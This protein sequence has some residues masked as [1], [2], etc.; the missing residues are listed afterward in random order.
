MKN[1]LELNT[2]KTKRAMWKPVVKGKFVDNVE[3]LLFTIFVLSTVFFLYPK[4][5]IEEFILRYKDS[6]IDLA[7]TYL[8]NII[9]IN[10]DLNLK[11]LLA[12]RYA[13]IGN[14]K[15]SEEI[16]KELENTS[17]RD[18][19]LLIRYE[20]LKFL[21]FLTQDLDKKEKYRK[22]IKTILENFYKLSYNL[23]DLEKSYKE[24]LSMGM[25]DV[26]LNIA[27]KISKLKMDRD[28]YWLKTV[29][30]D[31]LANE[32]YEIALKY[33]EILKRTDVGNYNFW[34]KE[35]Y[36]ISLSMG[37]YKKAL[38][39][40]L[41]LFISEDGEYRGDIAYLL[42]KVS[43]DELIYEYIQKYPGKKYDFLEIL[44]DFYT[45]QKRFKEAFSIYR[46]VYEYT[47]DKSRRREL[48]K[49]IVKM[50]L[51]FHQY[52]QVKVFI[53]DHYIDHI[54][55]LEMAKFVLSSSLATGDPNFSYKIAKEIY[56]TIK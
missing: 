33:C 19:V 37:D 7:N 34:L 5:K 42:S 56:R 52:E 12:Q 14:I 2:K 49:K 31:A 23:K 4:G 16:L 21:Y 13:E 9:R 18:K 41:T 38:D 36:R 11:L 17:L 45:S 30:K 20:R 32:K 39:N 1:L 27:I 6:N 15:R 43:S 47:K 25:P 10:N 8:E 22:D 55:D 46:E 54:G 40:A 50:L 28:I 51:A 48:F 24:S 44:A 35:E 53:N 26:A 3:I 29:Y